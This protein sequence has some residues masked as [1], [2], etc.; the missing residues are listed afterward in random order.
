[1]IKIKDIAIKCNTSIATVSKALHNSDELSKETIA[2]VQKVAQE[3]G[4]V[5]NA[6]ARALKMKR[7]FSI[8]II[9]YDPTAGGLKH[10][11]FSAILDSLKVE[12]ES[13]GYNITFL[14]KSPAS[15]MTYY[16]IAKYRNMDG[17]IVVSEDFSNPEIIELVNSGLPVVTIDYIFNSATAIMS[18]NTEGPER[19]VNYVASL[20]H[21]NIAFIH[22]ENTE[23]TKKRLAGFYKGM[24]E[25]GL[26]VNNDFLIEGRFHDPR[27]CGRAAKQLVSL[28]DR[29][30]CILCTDDIAMLGAIT[31]L[32]QS[33]YDIPKDM[34]L[35]GYDGVEI[36]RIFRPVFTTYVQNSSELGKQASINLISRIEEPNTFIPRTV[37]VQG[38]VQEGNTTRNINK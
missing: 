38:R 21:K 33:G 25:C 5:P 3:M 9:F 15:S 6:Y 28:S 27:A 8:G 10:E 36:S 30:T 12:A 4:Y 19:L 34:S 29:P 26:T 35:V 22:G 18:D 7:S 31:A 11:Y 20:G 17:V 13:K 32:N 16:Q 14:S 37:Y 24:Q 1:M 2:R 23:V